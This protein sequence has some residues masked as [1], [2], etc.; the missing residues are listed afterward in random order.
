[1]LNC[2]NRFTIKIINTKIQMLSN[3][4]L[5]FLY[6][7]IL[8]ESFHD[9]FDSTMQSAPSTV[10]AM[11]GHNAITSIFNFSG[12]HSN[13]EEDFTNSIKNTIQV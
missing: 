4:A 12:S 1:M 10:L 13:P 5:Y 7:Y 3:I 9:Q 2:L 8:W 6:H 11:S